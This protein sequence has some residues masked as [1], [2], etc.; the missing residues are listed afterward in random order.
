MQEITFQP[1][2]DDLIQAHRLNY[3]VQLRTGKF[4]RVSLFGAVAVAAILAL[5][6]WYFEW[7][8]IWKVAAVGAAYWI[9]VLLALA[10]V[11]Y[12]A[13][14]RNSRRV[15]AQQK[16]LHDATRVEWDDA[17]IAIHSAWTQRIRV[18]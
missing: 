9:V 17:G 6:S 2:Q 3:K 13:I 12:F 18:G 15:F 5:V 14:P 11:T 16:G 4:Y 8:P 7:Y 10:T 1:S